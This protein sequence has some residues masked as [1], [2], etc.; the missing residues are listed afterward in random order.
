M[1][2]IALIFLAA[3]I[4]TSCSS[5]SDNQTSSGG[6]DTAS[7]SGRTAFG[8]TS[9]S[10]S[11]LKNVKLFMYQIQ[12]IWHEG[13]VDALADTHYDMLIVE[14]TATQKGY[15]DF[16]MKGM[17]AKLH[18]SSAK[19]IKNKLVFAYVDIAEAEEWK[20][21]WQDGVWK[22]PTTK[23]CGHPGTPSFM[24]HMD[25]DD[26]EGVYP[27]AFWDSKWVEIIKD[28]F[29][30]FA[31]AGFDGAYLD[32]IEAYQDKC[33]IE[34]AKSQGIT[35]TAQKMVDFVKLLKS[36][37]R[38]Y[39]PNFMIISQNSLELGRDKPEYLKIIEGQSIEN[40]YFDG[41]A[42][43]EWNDPKIPVGDIAQD[44]YDTGEYIK[45]IKDVYQ[46]A[47][48]PVFT[49]DYAVVKANVDKAYKQSLDNGMIPLVTQISLS[50]IT[51]TPPPGY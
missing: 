3:F 33:V 36:Y 34:V 14:P 18:A 2:K 49:I 20:T 7:D 41:V 45:I 25:P 1:K 47:G 6:D 22:A 32:W 17:V 39:N 4:L 44:P 51:T 15:E 37:A 27:V 5:S 46:P 11:A 42:D 38:Q 24:V 16:D 13:A 31:E 35:D 30:R 19:N 10:V 12:H 21:Y 29:K 43:A 9:G 28:M 23:E 26:W 40:T 48:I 50:D 8:N